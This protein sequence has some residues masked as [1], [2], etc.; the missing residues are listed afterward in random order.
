MI[1]I[2]LY[3]DRVVPMTMKLEMAQQADGR[4]GITS[5]PTCL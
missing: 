1:W 4:G 5:Q 3:L 2:L